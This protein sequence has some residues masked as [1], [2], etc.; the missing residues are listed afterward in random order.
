MA[1][2]FDCPL[3]LP[4]YMLEDSEQKLKPSGHSVN[5]HLLLFDGRIGLGLDRTTGNT[6]RLI[7]AH[8]LPCHHTAL[9]QRPLSTSWPCA[10][11]SWVT[12]HMSLG[13]GPRLSS[14]LLVGKSHTWNSV[15]L[16]VLR[17]VVDVRERCLRLAAACLP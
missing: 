3:I 2:Q 10:C 15:R 5:L 6:A 8:R 16:C 9:V 4:P 17:Q 12:A 11:V 14:D 13:R 1:P 7:S